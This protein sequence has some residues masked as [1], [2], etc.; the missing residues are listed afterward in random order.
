MRKGGCCVC[1]TAFLISVFGSAAILPGLKHTFSEVFV[2]RPATLIDVASLAWP[3]ILRI[4]VYL[5]CIDIETV[6]G[7]VHIDWSLSDIAKMHKLI[8]SRRL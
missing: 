1:C 8:K 3:A 2:P 6:L 4:Y 5:V 7:K